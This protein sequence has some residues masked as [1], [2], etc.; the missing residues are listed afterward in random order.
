MGDKET[1]MELSASSSLWTVCISSIIAAARVFEY[2]SL[3]QV[4]DHLSR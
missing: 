1:K 2:V 3:T 4:M